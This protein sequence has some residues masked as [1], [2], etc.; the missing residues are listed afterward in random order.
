MSSGILFTLPNQ[1]YLWLNDLGSKI[2]RD[3]LHEDFAQVIVAVGRASPAGVEL[4]GTSFAVGERTFATAAHITNQN[5]AGLVLIVPKIRKL[6]DFQDTT[7]QSIQTVPVKI[8][9]YDPIHDIA[10]LETVDIRMAFPYV[11][12]GADDA[13]SGTSI[14]SA[15]FPHAD[16]G[17]LVL[18]QQASTVGARILMQAGPVKAKHL[19][20]NVQTR[21]GTSGSPVL[22]GNQNRVV[23]MVIGS[24]AP[25]IEG[26]GIRLGNI[27]PY[28]LHQTTHAVS[29]EYIASMI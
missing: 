4:L 26:G 17:R 8:R 10:I 21:P 18:T 13:P 29:A 6:S 24:Y 9:E 12:G 7:D 22:L 23:A 11:L 27:D 25:K 19:V 14:I 2:G 5:D 3:A 28:T 1:D 15:G 20:M 16:F